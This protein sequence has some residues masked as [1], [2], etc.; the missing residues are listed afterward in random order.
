MFPILIHFGAFQ[1]YSFGV[2][3]A[4][5]VL[6][7]LYLMGRESARSG[8]PEK[9]GAFDLVFVTVVA[10]FLGARIL[11]VVE[12]WRDYQNSPLGLFAI[13]EGGLIFYGG[14]AASLAAM[15]IF[16]KMR[17]LPIGKSFD[18][19]VPYIAL[20][21]AFGRVGCFLNG[22]CTGDICD[23]PWAVHFPGESFARHP[24]QLYEAILDVLLF[25][26]LQKQKKSQPLSGIVTCR[27]F[28]GYALIRFCVEF[29]RNSNPGVFGF[30]Y[31][32]WI[33]LAAL[34]SA[35][36]AECLIRHFSSK[37]KVR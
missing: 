4:L 24:A 15:F 10:G 12:N 3:V 20:T 22:C 9:D 32:Q 37:P 30:T 33:S 31:N 18:F 21:H 35:G 26:F 5:G 36:A 16:L 13:W 7:S 28:M 2:L 8:F 14:M 34:F 25:L 6:F 27:Y 23:L 11:Y 1:I 19:L 29:V 17:H